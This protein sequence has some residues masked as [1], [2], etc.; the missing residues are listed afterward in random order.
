MEENKLKILGINFYNGKVE[1]VVN[2]LKSGGLLVV[3]AA[4]GLINIKTDRQYFKSLLDAD[5][6]I[7]D[8]G[9]MALIWNLSHKQKVN[10]ISGLGF[11]NAFFADKEVIAT[12]NILLV[13]PTPKDAEANMNYLKSIGFKLDANASYLAPMYDKSNV[14]DPELLSIVKQ[15]RPAYVILNLGGGTQEKIGAYLKEN[16]DYK[17]AIICTGA[18]IAFL[19]GRQASIPNWADKFFL[20]WLFR[21]IEKPKLYIPRYIKAFKLVVLMIQFGKKSPI[22]I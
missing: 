9:Y 12:S 17:P 16:L 8:S 18:A 4:P 6:A 13:D 2:E 15:K 10:R 3:P 14:I 20:G 11:L 19:T 7:A 5:I 21:C 1:D 22:S